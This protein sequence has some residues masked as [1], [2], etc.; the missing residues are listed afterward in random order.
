MKSNCSCCPSL[1]WQQAQNMLKRERSSLEEM[2]IE[3]RYKIKLAWPDKSG[4]KNVVKLLRAKGF[5]NKPQTASNNMGLASVTAELLLILPCLFFL[6]FFGAH[7][8]TPPPS[9]I[10][11]PTLCPSSSW[12]QNHI[13]ENQI[14]PES[15]YG[16][17]I[18]ISELLYWK[19]L[20]YLW[21]S[22]HRK[23]CIVLL[24]MY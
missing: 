7:M 13:P 24:W 10:P 12:K 1:D 4:L 16:V 15:N 8:S 21:Y 19:K 20:Q 11:S 18:V 9:K 3:Q 2:T 6:L 23:N 22:T 17:T 14:Q 5:Q